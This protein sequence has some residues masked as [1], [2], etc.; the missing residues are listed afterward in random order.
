MTRSRLE[1]FTDGV[2][3]ILI[4]IMILELRID[5]KETDWHAL[6]TVWPKFA[7]YVMSFLYLGIYW[8]N[9][10]HFMHTVDR[11]NGAILWANIHLLFWLSLVPA[12]TAW[13]GGDMQHPAPTAVYG[14]SLLMPAL[15]WTIMAQAIMRAQ[16]PHSKLREIIGKDVKGKMSGVLYALSIAL[17]FV[18]PWLSA[19]IFVG[20][21]LIWVVPDRRVEKH[22]KE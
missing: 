11:V 22:F 6:V 8:V 17:A 10:H 3:A 13:W 12:T 16:G 9:H 4:T 14:L 15:A 7:A 20:V 19:A 18:S 5:D 21:G 1:A 2:F